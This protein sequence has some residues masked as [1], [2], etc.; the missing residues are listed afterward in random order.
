MKIVKY[1]RNFFDLNMDARVFIKNFSDNTRFFKCFNGLATPDTLA[2]QQAP[3][4][5]FREEIRAP[6]GAAGY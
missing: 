3:P 4:R 6:F 2:V 1:V 5:V